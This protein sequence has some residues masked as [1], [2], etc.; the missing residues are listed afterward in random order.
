[1]R[2]PTGVFDRR[3]A[4]VCA[5][6]GSAVCLVAVLQ[7]GGGAA[8][9][10]D[11]PIATATRGDVVVSV[12]GV[13]RIVEAGATADIAVPSAAAASSSS[14]GA[15]TSP[16]SA[17]ADA[18]FAR[19]IGHVARFLVAPGRHVSAGR[20]LAVLDDGGLAASGIAQARND[21][22]VARLE[23]QQKRTSD[24][25][26]GVPPTA[27]E[28][29]AADVALTSTREKLDTVL[30][31]ARPADLSAARLDVTR[32]NA[33]LE[34][35]RGGTMAARARAIALAQETVRLAQARLARLL[36]P[37]SPADLSAA[38]ADVKKAEADLAA[39]LKPAP[40]PLPEA[41]AAAKQAVSAAEKKLAQASGP[42]DPVAVATAQ[43]E[44][45]RAESDLADLQALS[46]PAS[47]QALAAGQQAL[48]TARAKLAQLTGPPD[49]AVVAAAQL[50][51]DRAVA[52]L[53]ALQQPAIAP[54]TE[55]IAAA[56]QA[57]EAARLKFAK[58]REPAN[59]ADVTSARLDV[60]RARADLR[61]LQ[62]G[63]TP[64]A[65]AAARAAVA[66]SQAK[67]AQL[68]GPPLRSDVTAAR[69]DVRKAEA[70][71][72]V[73]HARGGPASTFDLGLARL[74]VVAA[75]TRLDSARFAQRLLTV[76]APEAGTVTALLTVPGA[77][78]DTTTPILTV[79]NL[80]KLEANVGLSEFDSAQVRR[81]QSALVAVDA[82]GGK[83]VA[84]TV[85][86]AALTGSDN[87][88]VVTFPVRVH[89]SR[90]AGLKP[91]MNV[92]VRIVVAQRRGV[93]QLPL[94]A[95][96]HDGEDRPFVTVVNAS[97]A[98]EPRRV[99]LGL[100]NNKV[101]EIVK[102]V[103]AGEHVALAETQG[104]EE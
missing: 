77:P 100:S 29:A 47:P 52:E 19:T 37:A 24:P 70:D 74:K 81:G 78:V 103:R 39:L 92:S 22:A 73:L 26:K 53:A 80:S 104:G 89:L 56:Q 76:R 58:V 64:T 18:V 13:G 16:S 91:G 38:Q 23:L 96:S 82:L 25:L 66:S 30:R 95:V 63:P 101:V 3:R 87:G 44:V 94:E 40:A 36:A 54:S 83:T 84:G 5:I 97:G 42:A 93:V 6:L 51:R 46:P 33:D 55:A 67:L 75:R 61:T 43:L 17:P 28:L 8:A 49:P 14:G 69:L 41:V 99:T 68:T 59:P 21:L 11:A 90:S 20:P 27:A 71:R 15:T 7:F 102:G 72:A 98:D 12:G 88:G 48:D 32:S 2:G 4:V 1:M 35:L 31:G 9:Q 10:S 85:L 79:A 50:D 86:F 62:A 34:T 65:L 45:K 57:V 60:R